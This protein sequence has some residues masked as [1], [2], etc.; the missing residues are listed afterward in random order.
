MTYKT[1]T[2]RVAALVLALVALTALHADAQTGKIDDDLQRAQE[3]L[4]EL[5]AGSADQA[6]RQ[7]MEA[8]IARIEA[9]DYVVT[10]KLTT[11]AYAGAAGTSLSQ[12]RELDSSTHPL[13]GGSRFP[14][15]RRVE[16]SHSVRAQGTRSMA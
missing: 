8:E 15:P 14:N 3:I 5:A 13:K 4:N 12:F 16:P 9:H 10:V 1:Q 7:L 2:L 11:R 6:S